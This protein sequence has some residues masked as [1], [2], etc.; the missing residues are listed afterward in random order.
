MNLQIN[1]G[2]AL[3]CTFQLNWLPG[4]FFVNYQSFRTSI[5]Q[6]NNK[7]MNCLVFGAEIQ[8]QDPL[9]MSLLP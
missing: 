8:T 9:N 5:L 6:S 3:I 4:L 2:L 7:E 1:F